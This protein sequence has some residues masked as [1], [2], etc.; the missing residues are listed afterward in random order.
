MAVYD[1][2][3]DLCPEIVKMEGCETYSQSDAKLHN[4]GYD[5]YIT[6]VAFIGMCRHISE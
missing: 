6:G 1:A 4:A 2:Y 3:K 5:S